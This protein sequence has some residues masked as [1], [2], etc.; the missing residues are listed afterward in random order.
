MFGL[1]FLSPWYL[2]G[3]LAVAV[4]IALHLFRRRTETVV[5]FPAVR[6][7]VKSPV[8]QR[9]RRRLRELVLL[10][11]RVSALVLLAVA[12][13][14]PYVAGRMLAADT[15]VTVVAVDTS[16]SLSN[17]DVFARA[18]ARAEEAVRR[19]PPAHAVALVAFD[20]TASTIVE[21]TTDRGAAVAAVG[22]LAP[23]ASGTRYLAALARAVEIIGARAGRVTIVSDFQQG[24]WEGAAHASLPDDI[25]LELVS[26]DGPLQNVAVLSIERREGRVVAGVHNFG[27][28]P[29]AVPV[30]L[31]VDGRV[32]ETLRLDLAAQSA[33]HVAFEAVVPASGTASIAL[34]DAGG[35][36]ADDVRYLVLDPA[37]AA[38][39]AVVVADPSALR[40]GLYVERALGAADEGRE[41]SVTVVDGRAL[42]AWNASEMARHQALVVLG[43]RTLE[44]GGRELI[45]GFLASGG[46]MLLALGPDVDPGTLPDVLGEA[47]A[48][49]PDARSLD[50]GAATLVV[51]DTRH[52]VFR[53]F[54]QPT[55]ALGDVSFQRFRPIE[56]RGRTVLARFAGGAAALLEQMRPQGRLLFFTSD[57]DNQW[58]R[59]PL[60]PA[61]VPFIV[62]TARYLTDG[63]R[64]RTSWV[65]PATPSGL[66]PTPGVFTIDGTSGAAPGGGRRVAV[67]V[68]TRESNP[69]PMSREAFLEHVPRVPRSVTAD[70]EADA[71]KAEGEQR[72][73]Q[74]GLLVMFLAL[75]GEALVGRR[76]S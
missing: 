65:L 55:A 9:R 24:G 58:N 49:G 2:L 8:E 26:V 43:T 32:V 5:D 15:P 19:A 4:P 18:R 63:S 60:S 23:G 66:P 39:I 52:P 68:D 53:P 67:N 46:S 38:R 11:L 45:A 17:A 57:L 73:W 6:L 56:E 14:R 44:R 72:L 30:S 33:A 34:E 10:A 20:E 37:P 28:E 31:S 29:R 42:S 47:P 70:P 64:A 48:V 3:A 69:A 25:E 21:P 76:A 16:F 41:F 74:L 36:A 62:E 1:S 51:G 59:F 13:A 54:T 12:F 61:F 35:Y 50:G 27:L 22:G 71:R 7:L 40:G 75:A